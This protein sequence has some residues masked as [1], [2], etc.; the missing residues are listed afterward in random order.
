MFFSMYRNEE[1]LRP[2]EEEEVNDKIRLMLSLS[3]NGWMPS[4]EVF[5]NVAIS[6]HIPSSTGVLADVLANLA[7]GVASV[8]R[9]AIQFLGSLGSFFLYNPHLALGKDG[10]WKFKKMQV[11]G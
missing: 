1:F 7:A 11:W 5:I 9:D 6:K 2:T 10:W 4:A 8:Q 3:F